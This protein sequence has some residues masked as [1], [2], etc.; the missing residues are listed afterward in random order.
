MW[1]G[2]Q[3]DP[4]FR[5]TADREDNLDSAQE[6]GA[7]VIRT[8][9][10]WYRVAPTRPARAADP[11][12]DAYR[13]DDL[14]E[15]VRG[16]QQ[17]GM[18]VLL[19]IWGTPTWAGP[20][21]NRLPRRLT[22][23]TNFARALATR[24]SGRF[25][26]Y[27]FVRFYTV[28]NEPNREIF[29]APQYASNGKPVAPGNYA[30]LYR[31]GYAGIKAGNRQALV[32]AGATASN[33]RDRRLGRRGVQETMSPGRFAE[34][35]SKVRPAIRFDAWAH[36]PYPTTPRM[37]PTQKV[38][39]PNV[40]LASL[41]TFEKALD[42]WFKRR[43]IPVWITEYG[44]ETKPQDPRG[45]SYTTQA[46]YAVQ[47][48]GIARRDPHV[49]MFIWFILKDAPT[50]PW[51]SGLRTQSGVKKPAF[52]RFAAIARAVD[53]RNAIVPVRGLSP[54]VRASALPISYYSPPGAV[55]G[56]TFQIFSG[57]FQIWEGFPSA[58]LARDG[59][60]TFRAGFTPYRGGTFTMRVK[61]EDLNGN[62]VRRTLTLVGT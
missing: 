52:S 31:A 45:V 51:D 20:A 55:V 28:W 29:L 43:N 13:F 57:P 24:Y 62:V 15:M 16:A 48:L 10:Y 22:D 36:H 54:V 53:A 18:E 60:V 4:R 58:V 25:A 34:L 14:D 38:R 35:L 1:L 39:F 17:R 37:K 9:V 33:G 23:L 30:K 7:T 2:F 8:T 21:K 6:A 61:I 44:H 41:P 47:A 42:R 11:F 59:T 56:V 27:P 49:Q 12:D 26:G 32:A 46:A 19:T 3:D 50:T 5:W 40:S